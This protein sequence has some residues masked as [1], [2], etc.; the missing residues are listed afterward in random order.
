MILDDE[1][2]DLLL[3]YQIL[4]QLHLARCAWQT[5]QQKRMVFRL[6]RTLVDQV[7]NVCLPDANRQ[8]VR[9]QQ[10]LCRIGQELFPRTLSLSRL[11]KMSPIAR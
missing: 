3:V 4:E 7:L 6:V 2:N 9:Y 10:P 11:R 5:I 8:F 1:V